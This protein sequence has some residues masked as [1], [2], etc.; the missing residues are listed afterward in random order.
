[1]KFD[2]KKFIEEKSKE[3]KDTIGDE[4]AIC[5]TSGGVDSMTCALLAHK[6]IGDQLTTLF[7]DD[8]LMRENEPETVT[9]WLRDNKINVKLI[10]AGNDF[11]AALKGI[12]DPEEKRKVF[13]DTFYKTLGRAVKESGASFMIQ[14][15]IAADIV[16]TKGGIKTQHNVL[17]QIGISPEKY[18]LRIL[19]PLR[20]IYKPQVREVAKELGLPEEYHQRM[21]FPGP[22]LATRIIGEVTPER[23]TIL[24][25]ATEIVEEEILKELK[26]FQA[27]AVLLNDRATGVV[28]GKRAFGNII[29]V[30][31]VESKDAMTATVTEIPW[32]T[33]QRIRE[34]ICEEI[35]EVTRVLYDITP[36]PPGTIEYI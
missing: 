34:R 20:E 29:V 31:S 16:E 9:K 12:E 25:K 10:N 28:G 22:G 35:P 5:A 8:G 6:V 3:L 19:E 14:G 13:R 11:F 32:K 23:V 30:R 15:T 7:I 24:R 4:K 36:K 21:P 26:P 27:F 2:A 1:M 17:E 33:L 18:G